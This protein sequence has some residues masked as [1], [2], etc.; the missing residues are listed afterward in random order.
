MLDIKTTTKIKYP[1]GGFAPG[2]YMNVCTSCDEKFSGDKY[3]IQCEPC[4]I[5]AINESHS[6]AINKLSKFK[7]ALDS[8]KSAND[9]ISALINDDTITYIFDDRIKKEN[10]IYDKK[11]KSS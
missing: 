6:I 3:S 7:N 5:N 9:E 2:H 4:A 1:I 10:K 8:I 11:N